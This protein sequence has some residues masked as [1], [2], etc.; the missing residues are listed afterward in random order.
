M[1]VGL[2][3]RKNQYYDSVFL[4]GISKRISGV[5]GVQQNAVLMGSDAN[6]TLL[7]NIGII[8]PEVD[9]AQPNDLVVGV[10]ADT[11]DAVDVALHK[12]GEFLVG[13]VQA[14]AATNPR[15]I[16]EALS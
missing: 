9:A 8:G 16:E 2:V 11:P 15:S 5:P 12:L 3:I 6:K 1:A 14:S 7:T 10:I 4:M 13:G